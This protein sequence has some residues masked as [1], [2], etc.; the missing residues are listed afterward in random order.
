M[1]FSSKCKDELSRK[2]LE[3]SCCMV[4][5][6]A[7]LIRTTGYISIKGYNKFDIEF[8]MENAA[9]ARRI[10]K[11]I[12]HLYGSNSEIIVKRSNRLKKHNN[13]SVKVNDK[14]VKKILKDTKLIENDNINILEFNFG[15]PKN[16][17]N[18]DYCKRA[19]IRGTFLGCGSISDPEKSYHVEFVSNKKIHCT[20]LEK[21]INVYDL[22]AKRIVRKDLYITYLK[23][24]EKIV[25]LL[26]VMGAYNS[27]LYIENIRAIK[28]TRNNVNRV[29]NCETAN[30]GKIVDT[31]IRQKNSIM[32]LQKHNV[33]NKLPDGLKELA[34]LRLE[35]EDASLKELGEMLV[36]PLGK[37]GVNHRLKKIEKLAEDY[38]LKE[39]KTQNEISSC[40]NKK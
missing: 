16:L 3:N 5:E 18:N 36:P 11:M 20:D 19:Y 24:S 22:G 33:I 35:N 31:S 32:V 13:Y 8:V 29:V 9:V 4:S 7:A 34:Y 14:D 37:S 2:N 25:D 28:E 10:F 21:L 27:L 17:I 26:N 40:K 15:I 1:T 23:D 38:L 39:D 30:L 6:L 12:K